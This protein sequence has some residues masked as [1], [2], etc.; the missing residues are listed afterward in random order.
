MAALY[1]VALYLAQARG[2]LFPDEIAERVALM[3][4]LPAQVGRTLQLY[5][6]IARSPSGT[7]RARC[8]V[9]RPHTG[10]PAALEGALKLKEISY[11][12]AEGYPAG[13]LKHGPIALVEPGVP[14]VAI[15]TECQCT[16]RCSRTSRR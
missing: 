1:L 14:V 4:A 10:Y 12:H 11:I 13:E 8:A 9:H 7:G 3:H 2:T 6:R 16:R 15:A 5:D